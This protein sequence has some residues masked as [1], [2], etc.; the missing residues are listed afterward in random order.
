MKKIIVFTNRSGSYMVDSTYPKKIK[1]R[2]FVIECPIDCVE[3]KGKIKLK[4]KIKNYEDLVSTL[5]TEIFGT[6]E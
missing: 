1:G 4:N 6:Q 3:I 2:C 5:N